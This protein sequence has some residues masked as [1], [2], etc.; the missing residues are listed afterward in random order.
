MKLSK[1]GSVDLKNDEEMA[2]SLYPAIKN[3]NEI[4]KRERNV[5]DA[6]E[7]KRYNYKE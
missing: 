5:S 4:S 2:N 1:S 3:Y 7:K 6:I